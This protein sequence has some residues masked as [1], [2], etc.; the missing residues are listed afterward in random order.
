MQATRASINTSDLIE[1]ASYKHLAINCIS[2]SACHTPFKM[3]N[4]TMLITSRPAPSLSNSSSKSH[5]SCTT[6]KS[7]CLKASSHLKMTTKS[8]SS[9][10][11][12]T[13]Q[14]STSGSLL[15]I[16]HSSSSHSMKTFSTCSLI[17]FKHSLAPKSSA[18]NR[19][20]ASSMTLLRTLYQKNH[21]MIKQSNPST[22]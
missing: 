10:K 13:S 9:S 7:T 11:I 6:N 21:L 19:S 4:R 1:T 17:S 3:R 15:L 14:H 18:L 22:C 5:T 8:T 20:M 2:H 12:K 16:S